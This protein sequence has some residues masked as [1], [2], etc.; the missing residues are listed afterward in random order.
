M[1]QNQSVEN[2]ENQPIIEIQNELTTKY[3]RQEIV[4]K[5]FFS[6]LKEKEIG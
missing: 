4:N 6:Y 3:K 2:Q 5:A 1:S